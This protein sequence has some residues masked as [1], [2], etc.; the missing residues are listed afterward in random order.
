MMISPEAYKSMHEADSF[1]KLIEERKDL[2]G[3]LEQ[4][5]KIVRDK[6]KKDESWNESPGP[7]VRYQMT[8]SYLVQIF[9]LL[10]K[11]YS[12]EISMNE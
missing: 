1:D 7:D 2:L 10:W 8:L 4:L 3:Q 12:V 9:E 5:E 11:S 6:D